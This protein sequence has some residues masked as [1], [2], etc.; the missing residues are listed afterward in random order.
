MLEELNQHRSPPSGQV[1]ATEKIEHNNCILITFLCHPRTGFL[2]G[3]RVIRLVKT[4]FGLEWL[5]LKSREDLWKI[6][7][8]LN[9][10]P[11]S[12]QS[13][14]KTFVAP[15]MKRMREQVNLTSGPIKL[16]L[17]LSLPVTH[18]DLIISHV[19]KG[20][21]LNFDL[22]LIWGACDWADH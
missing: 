9:Y 1:S 2:C 11:I 8:R 12:L 3:T 17:R 18:S 10:V 13:W 6:L 19:T 15:G 14:L 4:I 22:A 20:D 16:L 5:D 21:G 7:K